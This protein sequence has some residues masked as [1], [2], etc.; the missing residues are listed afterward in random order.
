MLASGF[1]NVRIAE[2]YS[3]PKRAI[4][5]SIALMERFLARR[6]SLVDDE[7]RITPVCESWCKKCIENLGKV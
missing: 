6:F 4:V 3:N 5:V 2:R 7:G 1:M